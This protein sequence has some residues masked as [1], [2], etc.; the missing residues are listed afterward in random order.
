MSLPDEIRKFVL[1]RYILPA[2]DRNEKE[3]ILSAEV[4]QQALGRGF[5]ID[6]ICKALDTRTFLQTAAVTLTRRQGPPKGPTAQWIFDV[7]MTGQRGELLVAVLKNKGDLTILEQEGWY[8]IPVRNAPKRWPP[9]WLA[10]YQGAKWNNE[11]GINYY[12]PVKEIRQ[13]TRDELFPDEKPNR[14]SNKLYYQI[15][16][17]SLQRI[18]P[19]IVSRRPRVIIFIPTTWQKF[20]LAYEIND[21]YDDSPL[22]NLLWDSFK[23]HKIIAERQWRV[24][25]QRRRYYLDFAIFCQKANIAIEVDGY[26]THSG[27]TKSTADKKRQNDL[28]T[29]GWHI[30][31]FETDQI[32]HQL[33][34]YCIPKV[35]TTVRELDGLVDSGPI[36]RKFYNFPSEDL[37]QLP[38]LEASAG[39]SLD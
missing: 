4:V 34:G 11:R 22:E 27:R 6:R 5:A 2:R 15:F 24:Q 1:N 9:Q 8:R 17:G 21:L 30:L 12:A 20:L 35:K 31:R 14:K 10:F 26:T 33:E 29:T 28:T 23:H 13:A 32:R 25:V 37:K 16:V 19:P 3:I 38:L 7:S 39:Y 18:D 36:P